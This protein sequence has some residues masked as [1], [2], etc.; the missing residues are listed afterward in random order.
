MRID[1]SGRVLLGSTAQG[2]VGGVGSTHWSQ[3]MT[4][5]AKWCHT[6]KS[7]NSSPFGIAVKYSAIPNGTG[8]AFIYCED[9]TPASRFEVVSNGGIKNY[10]ANNVNLSDER[11]KKNIVDADNQLENIKNLIIKSFHYNEDDDS[12]DKRLGVIAQELETNL[13]HLVDEYS[14]GGGEERKGV[15]EQQLMWMAIKAIQELEARVQALEE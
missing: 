10:S 11:E 2:T 5:T 6:F 1:S 8:N 12:A 13:P 15:K 7:S 14:N 4:G 3:A 9:G